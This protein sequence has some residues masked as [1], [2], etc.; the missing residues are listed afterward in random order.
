MVTTPLPRHAD[1]NAVRH[2]GAEGM[3]NRLVA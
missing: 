1:P 3:S 2:G